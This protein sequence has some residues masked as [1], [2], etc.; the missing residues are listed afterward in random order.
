MNES[1]GISLDLRC[2]VTSLL[3]TELNIIEIIPIWPVVQKVNSSYS[4]DK[5]AIQ[6]I[7]HIHRITWVVQR[8]N[9][10]IQLIKC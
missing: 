7:S 5:S 9:S 1:F 10:A 4:V 6:C 8:V 2:M 3:N